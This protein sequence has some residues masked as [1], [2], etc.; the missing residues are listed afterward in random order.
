MNLAHLPQLT[1]TE[2]QALIDAMQQGFGPC[3]C[4]PVNGRTMLCDGHLF[5][6]ETQ[7]FGVSRETIDRV[8]RMV[9]ARREARHWMAGEFGITLPPPEEPLP[10]DLLGPPVP[11]SP[12]QG[13]DT[14]VLPW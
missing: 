2:Q 3:T 6:A 5:L 14:N 12:Q 4:R 9:L 11:E 13:D 1:R 7:A 8:S 10:P